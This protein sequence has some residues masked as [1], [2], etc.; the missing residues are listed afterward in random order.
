MYNLS[1]KQIVSIGPNV[2][3]AWPGSIQQMT[4]LGIS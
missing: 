3:S 1:M 2:F 4:L